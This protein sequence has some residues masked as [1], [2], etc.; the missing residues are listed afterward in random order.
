MKKKFEI[1][2]I[3]PTSYG[4]GV[5]TAAKSFL[6]YSS[7]NY[8]FNVFFLKNK[9]S[10]NSIKSYFLTLKKIINKQPA[11]ILTSLWKSNIITLLYKIFNPKV[12]YILFLHNTKNKHLVD[13]LITSISALFA[14]EIWSDS[15][16]TMDQRLNNL[17]FFNYKKDFFIKNNKKRI[18]SF[19]I[20]K[21]KPL[22][23]KNCNPS[24]IYWG[25]LSPVKNIDLAI[26]LFSEICRIEKKSQ[27]TII[28]PDYGVKKS[29]NLKISKLGLQKNIIIYDCM[30]FHEIKKFANSACFF[31]Q[32]SSYEGM[33]MSVSESMQLGLIPVVTAVGQ[34]SSYCKNMKNSVIYNYDDDDTVSNI[35][36]IVNSKEKYLRIRSASIKTWQNYNL[37]KNDV[38]SA[39][40]EVINFIK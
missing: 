15:I 6:S 2:H 10:E 25:R 14:Y 4:G 37:Y 17:Y 7:I 29:L 31:I 30:D 9:L 3:V 16:N 27:F 8:N 28:G 20:E 19:V 21:I 38:A 11:V 24:F 34:I 12:R 32:L 18:I 22:N 13:T 33:A 23:I 1:I 5:E 35:F 26:K 39:F 40:D 36:S